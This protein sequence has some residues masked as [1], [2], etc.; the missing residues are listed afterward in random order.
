MKERPII[1]RA[2][3]VRAILDGRK[4]QTRRIVKPQPVGGS[5]PGLRWDHVNG[6][7]SWIDPHGRPV[8]C[9]Y[10]APGDR[11]WVRERARVV[12]GEFGT[13]GYVTGIGTNNWCRVKYEA[14]GTEAVVEYPGRLAD[15]AIGHCIPNGCHREASR[16]TLEVVGVRVERLN[17]IS[18]KD[19]IA[20]GV[21][22]GQSLGIPGWKSYLHG[23]FV[24]TWPSTSFRGLWG[25]I[26]GP[27]SW[28]ANP[29]LWVVEFRRIE[30]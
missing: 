22:E 11:L 6:K 1:F 27:G 18:E 25:S 14:D 20:E 28:D 4:T 2:P 19:A 10:G 9:P 30:Q 24:C 26:Y 8:K 15:V 12:F 7:P 5:M 23:N 13:S 17:E 21:E 29:W 3:M 16:I